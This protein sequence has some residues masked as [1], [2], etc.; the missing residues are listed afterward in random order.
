MTPAARIEA[1]LHEIGTDLERHAGAPVYLIGSAAAALAGA[2][3][4]VADLDLLTTVEDAQRL[5]QAWSARRVHD[6]APADDARFRSRFARYAFAAMTV[7]VM[8]GL[9]VRVGGAW[10][11]LR[12]GSSRPLAGHAGGLRLPSIDE[13]L[14]V[15]GLFGRDKD[16]RRADLLRRLPAGEPGT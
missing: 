13:Q 5:E 9:E 1:A 2:E 11:A 12:I 16:R 6:Y 3:V 10:Q 14:R 4:E 8:G 15:L 7:E